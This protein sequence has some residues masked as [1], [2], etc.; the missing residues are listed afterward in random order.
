MYNLSYCIKQRLKAYEFTR[1][2]PRSTMF[3]KIIFLYIVFYT[4]SS[5]REE[6]T[7]PEDHKLI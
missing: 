4:F 6:K 1:L 5:N 2:F 3:M 7:A